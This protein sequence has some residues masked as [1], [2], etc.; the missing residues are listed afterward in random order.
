MKIYLR[1]IDKVFFLKLHYGSLW[2]SFYKFWAKICKYASSRDKRLIPTQK[3]SV[4]SIRPLAGYMLALSVGIKR[5]HRLEKLDNSISHWF[6][7]TLDGQKVKNNK[8]KA[9]QIY[10]FLRLGFACSSCVVASKTSSD[11]CMRR[12]VDTT[13]NLRYLSEPKVAAMARSNALDAFVL[14]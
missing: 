5:K 13:L 1:D 3:E 9:K 6:L 12:R 4:E 14:L 7:D 11:H 2:I 8:H 10:N